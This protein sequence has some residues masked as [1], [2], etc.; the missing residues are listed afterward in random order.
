MEPDFAL[1][2][3]EDNGVLLIALILV[4][5]KAVA[6]RVGIVIL[7]VLIAPTIFIVILYRGH[8]QWSLLVVPMVVFGW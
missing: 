7:L 4:I 2:L 3:L 5:D 8:S 1:L 6:N